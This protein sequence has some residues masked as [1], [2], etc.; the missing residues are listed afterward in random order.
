VYFTLGGSPISELIGFGDTAYR[1]IGTPFQSPAQNTPPAVIGKLDCTVSENVKNEN[2]NTMIKIL[3]SIALIFICISCEE[4]VHETLHISIQNRTESPINITLYPKAEYLVGDL[5][6]HSDH[7]G[8][9]ENTQFTLFPNSEDNYDGNEVLFMSNNLNTEP[10]MLTGKVFDSIHVFLENKVTTIKF[11]QGNVIG[12][13]ENIFSENS[14]WDYK[15]V[16]DFLPDMGGRNPQKYHSY[17]FLILEDNL[18]IS[19]LDE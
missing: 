13:T 5:Y 18:I 19:N 3:I 10:Y 17:R 4:E 14:I 16:E 15:I 7:G 1:G 12:Y 2:N 9:H 11:T 8:G 6:R